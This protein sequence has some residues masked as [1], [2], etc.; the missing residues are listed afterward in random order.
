MFVLGVKLL[1]FLLYK[2]P[3][4]QYQKWFLQLAQQQFSTP[5]LSGH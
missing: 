3:D 2:L 5:I 4:M 1:S